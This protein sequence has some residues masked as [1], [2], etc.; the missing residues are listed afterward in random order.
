M[1]SLISDLLTLSRAGRVTGEF[2]RVDP[3]EVI[4]QVKADY[5]ELIRTK[6]AEIRVAGPLPALW[7]DRDRIGQLFGNLVGN[8][9]KY[10]RSAAPVVEIGAAPG[11]SSAWATL[12]V[13]DNGIGIEPQ[14]HAKIFQIFRRLHTREEY[15]GTGAG[16]A[17]CQ[18]IVQAH[19][20]RIWV[21]SE[22]GRGSTFYLSLPRQPAEAP[23]IRTELLNAP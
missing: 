15:D 3:E 4:A 22:P 13:K 19:G 5:A 9:L 1:R 6:G 20:G 14:F 18:K 8:G 17:I 2:G 11:D 23:P 21:E 10:N 12:Y 7:G 16:L